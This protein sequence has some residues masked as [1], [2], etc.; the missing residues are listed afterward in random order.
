MHYAPGESPAG[1]GRLVTI[2]SKDDTPNNQVEAEPYRV[3]EETT[4]GSWGWGKTLVG[5]GAVVTSPLWA[6][7]AVVGAAFI[8]GAILFD[9]GVTTLVDGM[10]TKRKD[11]TKDGS[12]SQP[13]DDTDVTTRPNDQAAALGQVKLELYKLDRDI[14]HQIYFKL[15]QGA[16]SFGTAAARHVGNLERSAILI[17][18][19]LGGAG[20]SA[21]PVWL[22]KQLNLNEATPG[23]SLE[24][25]A[26]SFAAI[27]NSIKQKK[28][29][30]MPA[31]PGTIDSLIRLV[32]DG[33]AI[34]EATK[35]ARTWQILR[36][37]FWPADKEQRTL[38]YAFC[39]VFAASLGEV[40]RKASQE[41]VDSFQTYLRDAIGIEASLL[42][43]LRPTL[44][45][46]DDQDFVN[47]CYAGNF[48]SSQKFGANFIGEFEHAIMEAVEQE[49]RERVLSLWRSCTSTP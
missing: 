49:D 25:A 43:D 4:S 24:D 26:T 27:L 35:V 5:L 18:E 10:G 6:A 41:Q 38:F 8:G 3:A 46:L 1:R 11:D 28:S 14:E 30:V 44:D 48:V 20:H 37:Q 2:I 19:F 22:K 21:F 7:E 9:S 31:I 13:P 32:L 23:T 15:I 33:A 45:Q 34:E 12:G 42:V 29:G 47:L 39:L 16:H 40:C 36:N 17:R